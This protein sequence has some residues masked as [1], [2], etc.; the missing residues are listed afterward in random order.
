MIVMKIAAA[1]VSLCC[2]VLKDKSHQ[3]IHLCLADSEKNIK[4]NISAH[5]SD[6]FDAKNIVI[7]TAVNQLETKSHRM[8]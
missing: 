7:E 1:Y 5:I 2:S 8:Q 3:W 4:K 6:N